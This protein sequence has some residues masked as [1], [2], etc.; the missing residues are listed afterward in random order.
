MAT[1][2]TLQER[3]H[4]RSV[5]YRPPIRPRQRVAGALTSLASHGRGVKSWPPHAWQL[6]GRVSY[7]VPQ[8]THSK[9]ARSLGR[10]LAMRRFMVAIRRR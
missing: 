3:M 10:S 2:P 5:R 4:R 9:T 8:S 1:D 7:A 6:L